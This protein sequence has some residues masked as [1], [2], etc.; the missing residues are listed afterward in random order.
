MRYKTTLYNKQ[1]IVALLSMLL[2]ASSCAPVHRFTRVKNIPREYSVNTGGELIRTPR[3]DLNREPWV[4]F[5]DRERSQTTNS[6]GGRVKAQDVDFLDPFLVIGSKNDYLRLIRYTPDIL[7]NGRLDFRNAEYYGWIHRSRLLLNQQS[8]TDIPSGRRNRMITHFGGAT[9]LTVPEV[10]FADEEI[11]LFSDLEMTT[12]IGTVP[13]Y[14]I[15]YPLR[16]SPNGNSTLISITPNISPETVQEEVLGW[17]SSS[18]ITSIGTGLFVNPPSIPQRSQRFLVNENEETP[19]TQ[20]LW[21]ANREIGLAHTPLRYSPVFTYSTRDSLVAFRTRMMLPVF[22]FSENFVFNVDGNPISRQA[23]QT[24]TNQLRRINISFVFDGTE[25]TMEQFPQIVNALQNLQPLFEQSN[26]RFVYQFNTVMTFGTNDTMNRPFSTDFTS[27]FTQIINFLSDKA[28]Q[29]DNLQMM[30][31]PQ[32]SWAA[33]RQSVALFDNHAD[34]TNLIVLIGDRRTTGAAPNAAL[35]DR[36]LY[37]N[38]RIIG[39]QVYAGEGNDYNNFVLDLAAI[40]NDYSDAMLNSKRELLVS[41][42][43][44]RRENRFAFVGDNEGVGD[45][46]FRLDFPNNSIT[47]G[48]LFFPQKSE[49]LSMEMLVNNVD[50]IL[51][52]IRQGN[53][54][55][56]RHL[57]QAFR[58]AGNNRTRLDSL[59]VRNY[60]LDTTTPTRNLLSSFADV[61]PLWSLPS[62]I[63]VF[64]KQ[65]NEE[66]EYRLLLSEQEMEDLREFITSLSAMEIDF[67]EDR[68]TARQNR[69]RCNCEA[70]DLFDELERERLGMT[71]TNNIEASE[72]ASEEI[73]SENSERGEYANTR[74]IRRHLVNE[75]VTAIQ[76]QNLLCT[77]RRENPRHLTLAE[78]QHRIMGMPTAT[79]FL[80]TFTVKDL[81]NRKVVTDEI[82]EGLI[83]YFKMMAEKLDEA[84]M[85]E[86]NG[87]RYFWVGRELLP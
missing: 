63:I 62:G 85:F 81:R 59:F 18:L 47:Q 67:I 7:N 76:Q 36:I 20:N 4:V 54:A 83:E 40:I 12:Q 1:A 37:N 75:F 15:I 50:T 27:D 84:E 5:S 42:E 51:Q 24:I 25:D 65:E 71:T 22:D 49:Y 35:L 66:I 33:L 57:S 53:N 72:N 56:V 26:D 70:D 6:A 73:G 80:H 48:A 29:R 69:Q 8:V 11:K 28:A 60:S 34:A 31:T 58:M 43:Q 17:I 41:P 78:V 74:R 19:I 32:Y 30:T 13:L 77:Q 52:E 87:N 44:L 14:S 9:A 82:L 55:I 10:F 16:Q 38:C 68:A 86:S 61:E 79:S 21:E 64:N 2:L 46:G 45:N 3:S 39:F 23:Y